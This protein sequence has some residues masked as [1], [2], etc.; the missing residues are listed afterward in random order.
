MGSTSNWKACLRACFSYC[1]MSGW[2]LAFIGKILGYIKLLINSI[3]IKLFKRQ[4]DQ[5]IAFLAL[6]FFFKWS[7]LCSIMPLTGCINSTN[8]ADQGAFIKPPAAMKTYW[9]PIIVGEGAIGWQ[10]RWFPANA[11][12]LQTCLLGVSCITQLITLSVYPIQH[13]DIHVC[14]MPG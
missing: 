10:R 4:G 8:M 9:H 1:W 13:Y 11:G 14:Q 2:A 3:F 12:C 5:K 7:S 6:Y